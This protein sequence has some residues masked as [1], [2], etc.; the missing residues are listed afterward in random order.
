MCSILWHMKAATALHPFVYIWIQFCEH[1]SVRLRGS[2][3]VENWLNFELR[4]GGDQEGAPCP[5]WYSLCLE[6]KCEYKYEDKY[7]H[8]HK[9]KN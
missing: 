9:D 7:G 6:D 2:G 4:E 5:C 1:G 3:S 8:K